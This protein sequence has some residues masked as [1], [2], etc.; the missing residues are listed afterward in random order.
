MLV[1]VWW[2][3]ANGA[4][5]PIRDDARV[6]YAYVHPNGREVLYIGKAD[7]CSVRER[8]SYQGKPHFW[9]WCKRNG[10]EGY[11]CLV[12]YPDLVGGGRLT[13]QLLAD[14]EG[15]LIFSMQPPGNIQST[16]TRGTS[17]SGMVVRCLGDWRWPREFQD[18]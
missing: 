12:G 18:N 10:I 5:D 3:R 14:I 4:D 7:G 6:L 2:Q 8:S 15:L 17:R 9:Q 16:R 11:I 1:Q 13:I